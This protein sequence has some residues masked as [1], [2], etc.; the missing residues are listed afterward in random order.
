[1]HHITLLTGA[2]FWGSLCYVAILSFVI[3]LV[4]LAVIWIGTIM[5]TINDTKVGIGGIIIGSVVTFLVQF[6]IFDLSACHMYNAFYRRRPGWANIH[7]LMWEAI[8]IGLSILFVAFRAIKLTVAAAL[9][10][11]RIDIPFLADGVGVYGGFMLDRF[12]IIFQQ[13][14]LA[15]EAH[16]HPFIERLGRLYL[17]KIRY[18]ERF[19]STAGNCW[20][21]VFVLTLFPWLKKYRV[22]QGPNLR[23]QQVC[24]EHSSDRF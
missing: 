16:S 4:I 24:L 21:L 17:L 19:A 13:D 7:N 8:W 12:P 10:I 3:A 5:S 18:G 9:Q 23:E 20:R 1:M 14:I 6:I 22:I 15:H 11:G 2:I